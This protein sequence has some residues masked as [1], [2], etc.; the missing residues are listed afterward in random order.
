MITIPQT[1]QAPSPIPIG[2]NIALVGSDGSKEFYEVISR[3]ALRVTEEFSEIDSGEETS[4]S[5]VGKIEPSD[6]VIYQIRIGVLHNVRL[7]LKQPAATTK[8]GTDSD[9]DGFITPD[10]SPFSNP[11]GHWEIYVPPGEQPQ[12]NIENPSENSV[13]ITPE[14]SYEGY[15][16]KVREISE[17]DAGPVLKLPVESFGG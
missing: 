11:E 12:L 13:P 8:W 10:Q 17:S 2:Y 1:G 6:D 16:Y 5:E 4:F 14:V 15:R 7:K 9:P 3:D